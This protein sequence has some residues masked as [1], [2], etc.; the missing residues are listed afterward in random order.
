VA[1]EAAA[2]A[3]KKARKGSGRR[4]ARERGAGGK[5]DKGGAALGGK[6][7]REEDPTVSNSGSHR[8]ALILWLCIRGIQQSEC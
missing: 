1:A 7:A 4:A 3:G 5:N 6:R 2:K 8:S